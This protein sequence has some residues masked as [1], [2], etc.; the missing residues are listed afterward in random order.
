MTTFK[1]GLIPRPLTVVAS[2]M[3][4][5]LALNEFGID[6][7]EDYSPRSKYVVVL[8]WQSYDTWRKRNDKRIVSLLHLQVVHSNSGKGAENG[9][10]QREPHSQTGSLGS[11]S[12]TIP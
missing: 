5:R 10:N 1:A 12:E 4:M 11:G 8:G 3:G 9:T 7:Y 2:G 6:E